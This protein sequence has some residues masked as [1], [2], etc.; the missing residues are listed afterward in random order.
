MFAEIEAELAA[1]PEDDPDSGV[2]IHQ[3]ELVGEDSQVCEGAR[4]AELSVEELRSR[5]LAW[6][7]KPGCL[8]SCGDRERPCFNV[9]DPVDVKW[10]MGFRRLSEQDRTAAVRAMLWALSSP[11]G[12]N[13]DLSRRSG[14]A[15][16][17]KGDLPVADTSQSDRAG[18]TT[19]VYA[20]RGRR[21]CL[22]GFTAFT[23]AGPGHQRLHTQIALAFLARYAEEH[24][25]YCPSGAGRERDQ[26]IQILPTSTTKLQ[27]YQAY[28]AKYSVL[29]ATLSAKI[30]A[31]TPDAVQPSDAPLSRAAFLRVWQA[32]LPTLRIRKS[33]SDF[34]DEC[35]R[36][37]ALLSQSPSIAET[38]AAHRARALVE[39]TIYQQTR[40]Q[41]E[42]SG[43]PILHL[44]FDFAEKVLLPRVLDQP[45]KMYFASGLKVDLF[46]VAISNTKQQFNYVLVE[47]HWPMG[48]DANRVCSML[49][50]ALADP[51][52]A[53]LPQARYLELHADNCAGQNK[54][55]FVMQYLAWRIMVGLSET[56][57]LHFMV[58]GHTKNHCDAY[59]GLIKRKL[60][61]RDVWTPRDMMDVVSAS[62]PASICKPG[63]RVE[64]IDWKA[65]L[66]QYFLDKGIPDISLM[67]HFEF[68]AS[69]PGQVAIR[70]TP[71]SAEQRIHLLRPGVTMDQVAARAVEDLA[72]MKLAIPS[73]SSLRATSKLN[74]HEY[75]TAVVSQFP[76][77]LGQQTPD[78]F[79]NGDPETTAPSS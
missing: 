52:L 1:I 72:G 2:G 45:G 61:R 5:T 59:F 48:K 26:P 74:R 13:N 42:A 10:A 77:Q 17:R 19:T 54:N 25:A 49:H 23:Q 27:V 58:L 21:V 7:T 51:R 57:N 73:L 64:W 33:G 50:D 79:G 14:P 63:N 55:R 34:C 22:G 11:S 65:I 47:G 18:R 9:D 53:S 37:K 41:A 31:S 69:W 67:S 8:C 66:G 70:C 78:F 75:L 44:T 29:A 28:E 35:G 71:D 30:Q 56:I 76:G 20:I 4:H 46:G 60:R 38:L 40:R 24:A 39:R 32:H 12:I 15:K 68:S 3:D 43:A 16:K 36:L 62:C 6:A